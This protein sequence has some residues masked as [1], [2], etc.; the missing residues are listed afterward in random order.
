[1]IELI[2]VSKVYETPAV[3]DLS[4]R[5]DEG[6][7]FCLLGPSGCGKTTTLRLVAGLEKPSAGTVKIDG[8]IVAGERWVEPEKRSIGIV[9]QD[10]ALFPHMTVYENIRFAGSSDEKVE[11]LLNLVGMKGKENRYPHELSGGEQQR[12]AIARALSKDPKIL[13]LD[14][15]FSNLDVD[16][17]ERL[18]EEVKRIL[19]RAETTTVFVT[20]DQ[21]EA[22][23]MADRIGVMKDGR[24]EQVGT[25]EEIFHNPET[26]F[27]ASFVG[28]A[29]F[30]DGRVNNGVVNTAI[31]EIHR[32][33]LGDNT[34][35]K[36]MLRPDYIDIFPDENGECVIVER[37]FQGMNYLYTLKLP[38]G[39]TV[40]CVKHHDEKFDV[41]EKVRVEMKHTPLCFLNYRR[42]L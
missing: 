6:E 25:P 41:G 23:Y 15:P 20:H 13:L 31:G 18:R 34:T 27:V 40:R 22:F 17:R 9:F 32:K 11:E 4:L 16:L 21:D 42:F 38:S 24:L 7:I 35:V 10:Y 36:V 29:D 14:E 5:V 28:V 26:I 2:N 3:T 37:L 12:V 1:M 19:I 39:E 33:T 8:E 30:I